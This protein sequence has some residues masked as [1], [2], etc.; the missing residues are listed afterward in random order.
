MASSELQTLQVFNGDVHFGDAS[1][2]RKQPFSSD[3]AHP[4]VALNS[5]WNWK[6]RA[7][8]AEPPAEFGRNLLPTSSAPLRRSF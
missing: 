1:L 3:I 4:L 7:A 2:G 5:S 8:A 6:Q